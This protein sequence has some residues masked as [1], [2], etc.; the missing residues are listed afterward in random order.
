MYQRHTPPPLPSTEVEP[1]LSDCHSPEDICRFYQ[2]VQLPVRLF[3]NRP[4][5]VTDGGIGLVGMPAAL[6]RRVCEALVQPP[7][8]MDSHSR[9]QMCIFVVNPRGRVSQSAWPQLDTLGMTIIPEGRRILLPTSDGTTNHIHWFSPPRPGSGPP[10]RAAVIG[11]T[12]T[13]GQCE[14]Q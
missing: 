5:L 9:W 11:T 7:V 13:L 14:W 2:S 6:G 4:C 1:E 8:L 12:R 10:P 3:G